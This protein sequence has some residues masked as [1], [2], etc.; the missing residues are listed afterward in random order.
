[1]DVVPVPLDASDPGRQGIG[2]F[3]YAGGIE[4]K[5]AESGR[6]REL[7]DLSIDADDDL[8]SVSD[9]GAF[10]EARLVWDKDERLSGLADT[11]MRPLVDERGEPLTGAN[12]DAEGLDLFPNGDRLVSFERRHRIWLYPGDGGFPRPVPSPE[13]DLPSNEG[14]EALTLYPEAGLDAYLVG[15]EDGTIWLCRLS[16]GCLATDFGTLVPS[17]YGLTSLASYGQSGGFVMLARSYDPQSGN[18]IS[19]RI[20]AA[21]GDRTG[22]VVDEMTIARPLTVDNFEGVAA[23]PRPPDG[24][25]IFI[26]SD[27]NGSSSQ[28]TYLLAFDWQPR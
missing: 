18:R 10:F 17:G 6:L 2:S 3:T 9:D 28:R 16:G 23:V 24:L 25:R 14:L 13:A 27:D 26:V 7:S 15:S 21:T 20:V 11:R 8:T 4:I 5:D 19:V 12:A 1:V 22:R